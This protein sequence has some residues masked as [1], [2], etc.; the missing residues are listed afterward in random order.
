MSTDPP[1]VRIL[2]LED[3][4]DDAALVRLAL[5]RAGLAT[6]IAG[7]ETRDQFLVAL[8]DGGFDVILADFSLPS[9]DGL[10][11][12][13]AARE[14]APETP[15]I[16]VSG[17]IGEDVAIGALHEGATDYVLKDKL[18]RLASAIVR[19]LTE[20]QARSEHAAARAALNESE[21]LLRT[22]LEHAPVLL[23]AIDGDGMFR[24]ATG[25][26]LKI[27]G[28]EPGDL[29]G[30]SIFERF[31]D[32]PNAVETARRAL[33]GERVT[34]DLTFGDATYETHFTPIVDGEGAITGAVGVAIDISERLRAEHEI[35]TLNVDLERRAFE[36]REAQQKTYIAEL[37]TIE[38][39]ALAAE[40]KDEDTGR[41]I[42]R[43]ARYCV[44]IGRKL[45]LATDDLDTLMNAAPMHD[46]GKMGIPDSI[47]LKPGKLD[48][49]EWE[50]MKQHAVIGARILG[51]SSSELLQA[52]ETIA[53]SH[54]EKWDGSGYPSGLAGEDIPL[55]GRIAAIADVFDALTSRRP[56]KEAFSFEK[57]V[58][59]V[60]EG[61]ALHFDPRLLDLFLSDL[62][63]V[64]AIF[65]AR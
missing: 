60:R 63:K 59:I 1:P 32:V 5:E 25:P 56:Y 58:A 3:N 37:E 4:P 33:A 12:L 29:V 18:A 51:G 19:A 23:F 41:H 65:E 6:R 26:G 45:G 24:L 50:L 38:R 21:A 20:T 17:A 44:L 47:L 35:L 7:A 57:A 49:D 42:V 61:R 34:R 54:H 39:L 55:W 13:R 2:H 9:Y 15:F 43:M 22:T 28:Y 64:H 53:L 30:L 62:D 27:L 16:F 10:S 36:A 14:S 48:A 8:A 46:V 52:G 31:A 11:A 40:Y